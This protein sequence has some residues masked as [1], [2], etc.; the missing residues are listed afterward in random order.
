MSESSGLLRNLRGFLLAAVFAAIVYLIVSNIH[1]FGNVLLVLLGFGGVVLVHEFGH[2]IVAK[3]SGIKV[4]VFSIFMPPMLLGLRKTES[5]L[6]FRVLPSLFGRGDSDSVRSLSNSTEGTK[7]KAGETEY[8]IGLIP[9]GGFVKLLGQDDIGSV[10]RIEDPR[11][12]S[13]KP[14]SIRIPVIAAGVTFNVISAGIIFVIVFLAGIRLPPAVVGGV[15]PDSPAA[16]AGIKPGDEIIEIAG[17]RKDL[18]FS[19]ILIASALSNVDEVVQLTVRHEDGSQESLGLVAE[20]MPGESI[21]EFGIIQPLSLTIA[22]VSDAK[23]LYERTGLRPGDRIRSVNGK[24]VRTHWQLVE[25]VEDS[26]VP[27]VTLVAE[28][29]TGQGKSKLVKSQISLRLRLADKEVD[30]EDEL[31]HIYSMVPR[32]RITAAA[33]VSAFT[34]ENG[35]SFIDRIKKKLG[36]SIDADKIAGGGENRNHNL[37]DGDIVLAIGDIE[38]PTYVEMRAV[39]E[40]YENKQLPLKVLR[41]DP[42]RLEQVVSVTVTP[43]R[44]ADGERAMIGVGLLLDTG[45]PVVAKTI[46]A[47]NGPARLDIPRGAALTAVNGVG[48]E[49][50]YDIVREITHTRDEQVVIDYRQDDGEAGR[51]T[52]KVDIEKDYITVKSVFAEPVPFGPLEKLYRASGPINAIGMGYR[53]TVM[54]VAQ[55]YVTLKHLIGGLISPKNLIGP[56][57]IIAVSYRIVVEQPLVNYAYFLGL[58]SAC[59]A[60]INLLP[61]P[62]FDGGLIVLMLVE[63]IKGS[64]ISE[65]AQGI[66]AYAGWVLVGMLFL[67]VTFNDIVRSFFG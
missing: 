53:R 52:L 59:I 15:V 50:F 54:F 46:S 4:E 45:H 22:D 44:P 67:Y 1:I 62:P 51:T 14:V 66:A 35:K 65:R 43:R 64:A 48:V 33:D 6:Q 23:T 28:R 17:K 2:F 41:T 37:K 27:E 32:L 18:D 3:L 25:T 16:R 38:N 34:E 21:R 42:N 58:I 24:D 49:D 47:E 10:K 30:S 11:S 19:N 7:D 57:G 9:F 39:T 63:R 61:L 8:R 29:S 55:T 20:L 31:G 36:F 12:F 13:N 5:G 40:Q 26:I 60:V 56:V